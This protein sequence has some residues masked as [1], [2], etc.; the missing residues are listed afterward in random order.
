MYLGD[1]I[2]TTKKNIKALIDTRKKT[3]LAVNV[4]VRVS[5][6]ECRAKLLQKEDQ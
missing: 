1:N 5:S 3:G 6:P 4:Y 2:N